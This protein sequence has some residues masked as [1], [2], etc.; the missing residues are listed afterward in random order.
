[1]ANIIKFPKL[2]RE[3]TRVVPDR[4]NS[5]VKAAPAIKSH[6]FLSGLDAVVWIV[7]VLL[8]PVLEKIL[9]IDVFFQFIR[10]MYYWNTPAVHAGWTFLLHFGALTAL[11]CYVAFYKPKGL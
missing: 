3:S 8:S 7:V 6:R 2:P 5:A 9:S 11:I 4:P 10:M 1:M